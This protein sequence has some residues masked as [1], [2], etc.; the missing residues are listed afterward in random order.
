MIIKINENQFV[1]LSNLLHED[2][3][4]NNIGVKGGKKVANL[5]YRKNSSYNSGNKNS[6]DMIKTSY[7]DSNLGQ[8]TYEVPIKGGLISYNITDISGVEVMHYFKR[9]FEKERTIMKL[10]GEEYD[11]EMENSEF[12][13]FMET[14]LTKVG[15]V[16]A[17]RTN[18]MKSKENG[19]EFSGICIYPV[20]SSSRFN[21]EMAKRIV[22]NNHTICGLPVQVLT[23]SLLEK[24]TKNLEID[25][26]FIEKNNDYYNSKRFKNGPHQGSHLDDVQNTINKLRKYSNI[27][28]EINNANVVVE[29]LI[30][31][32]Y[33]VNNCIKK[34]TLSD[35]AII[36]LSSLFI[37]YQK[38]VKNI[39]NA[40]NWFDVIA[41]KTHNQQL[42]M[43]AK[44]IKYT[45]GPS[46]E[47]RTGEIYHLLKDNG[48]AKGMYESQIYDVCRW[49]KIPFHIKKLGNDIRMALKNYFM[50]NEDEDL[51]KKEVE[52]AKNN[53]V[54][55]FDDNISGGA[56]LGD[57]CLQLK[58]LGMNYIIPI[59][60]GKMRV[61]YNQGM[62]VVIN[63]PEKGFNF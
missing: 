40:S 16:V 52:K 36:N 51:V 30:K 23:P 46:V 17:Y 47:K 32:Y 27:E 41:N 29:K 24:N 53:V 42:R 3:Y 55:V 11:L 15:N 13:D 54:V 56:T 60:F 34:G 44:S 4:V 43:I 2:V 45:K 7:M 50:A 22:K 9:S 19:L 39:I 26:D 63:K 5:T 20:P 59:T 21:D 49:E 33:Y 28:N 25:K 1:S 61:S 6:T 14:F 18:E 57:I 38:C 62:N 58:K 35:K 37:E 31:Q 10:N 8:N 48:F 12:R